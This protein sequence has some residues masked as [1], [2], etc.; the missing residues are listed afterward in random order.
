MRTEDSKQQVLGILLSEPTTH[1]DVVVN[2]N[3]RDGAGRHDFGQPE[4]V[5]AKAFDNET[6]FAA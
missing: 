4:G 3:D 1:Q 6:E 2:N 5:I